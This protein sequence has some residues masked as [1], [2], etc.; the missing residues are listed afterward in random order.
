MILTGQYVFALM[1]SLQM[2]CQHVLLINN[3][4][5]TK[6]LHNEPAG[7]LG[8]NGS[9]R[10]HAESTT[11][12]EST[13][14]LL[15]IP[16]LVLPL[17]WNSTLLWRSANQLGPPHIKASWNDQPCTR[18]RCPFNIHLPKRFSQLCHTD[19]PL[20]S[21]VLCFGCEVEEFIS[22][23]TA[24]GWKYSANYTRVFAFSPQNVDKK[25]SV[26]H[27]SL[28]YFICLFCKVI[29]NLNS[30]VAFN[31]TFALP[32]R[33]AGGGPE[34]NQMTPSTKHT[35]FGSSCSSITFSSESK[36]PLSALLTFILLPGHHF[37]RCKCTAAHTTPPPSSPV[38]AGQSV[39][40]NR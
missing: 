11:K 40:A 35:R 32:K 24:H 21:A 3:Q 22:L 8:K 12:D 1:P 19:L 39:A 23:Y 30:L 34:R 16:E 18:S 27:K 36:D 9:S 38:Q 29:H 13:S 25:V 2:R 7:I 17:K 5:Q 26:Q 10:W 33:N 31:L 20:A 6:R 15:T 28:F 37:V 4:P 14:Q